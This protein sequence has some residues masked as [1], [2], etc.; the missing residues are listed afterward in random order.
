M[1]TRFSFVVHRELTD[2]EKRLIPQLLGGAVLRAEL[3]YED[4]RENMRLAGNH[5]MVTAY[6]DG[7][8]ITKTISSAI[9]ASGERITMSEDRLDDA[10]E[11]S[12]LIGRG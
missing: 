4:N 2:Q 12:H 7:L 11:P 6:Q 9:G 1:T 5:D 10:V 3:W 8:E